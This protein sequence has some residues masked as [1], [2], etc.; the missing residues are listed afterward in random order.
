MEAGS[1]GRWWSWWRDVS[2]RVQASGR[3]WAT[4]G[5]VPFR[6]YLNEKELPT[7]SFKGRMHLGLKRLNHLN[8]FPHYTNNKT[9][10]E[11][12]VSVT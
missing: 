2:P 12:T 11:R 9:R 7:E 10:F 5:E 6:N 8:Y 3:A 4:L 1:E